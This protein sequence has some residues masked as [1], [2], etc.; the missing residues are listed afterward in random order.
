MMSELRLTDRIKEGRALLPYVIIL[1][2]RLT[3]WGISLTRG[4]TMD[5]QKKSVH[6]NSGFS[7]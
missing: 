7:V 3:D 5:S 1:Y 6:L 4:L 2:Q